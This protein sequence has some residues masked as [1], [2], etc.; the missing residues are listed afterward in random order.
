MWSIGRERGTVVQK[1][2]EGV[3][4]FMEQKKHC[5]VIGVAD[6]VVAR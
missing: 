3:A 6:L 4:L 5:K 1:V 2:K